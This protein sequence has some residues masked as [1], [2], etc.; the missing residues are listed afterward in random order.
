MTLR[1]TNGGQSYST[2]AQTARPVARGV[3]LA[4]QTKLTK[5]QR[6]VIAANIFDGLFAYQ[7]SQVELAKLLGV[8]APMVVKARRLSPAA[9]EQIAAGKATLATFKAKLTIKR[10]ADSADL[11]RQ[12]RASR[13]G[14]HVVDLLAAMEAAE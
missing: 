14:G 4:H 11:L 2:G 3:S 6:A 12:L 10:M 13:R 9:R 8:S 5:S 7:P 1:S